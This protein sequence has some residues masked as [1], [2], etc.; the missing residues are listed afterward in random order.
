MELTPRILSIPRA[1]A[2]RATR[3][4]PHLADDVESYVT[5]RFARALRAFRPRRCHNGSAGLAPWLVR[6]CALAA[7]SRMAHHASVSARFVPMPAC[8]EQGESLDA[9]I[10]APA[11]DTDARL[12]AE[13]AVAILRRS[14]PP[15]LFAVLWQHHAEGRVCRQIAARR[16]KSKA[17]GAYAVQ[18]ALALARE[19]LGGT[20]HA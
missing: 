13:E 5:V 2:A 19:I 9:I 20:G 4:A 12:D 15:R 14:M 8:G 7:R 6:A 10:P 1:I 3:H 11:E 16:R 17:W 18:K